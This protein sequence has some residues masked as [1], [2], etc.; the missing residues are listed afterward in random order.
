MRDRPSLPGTKDLNC[1]PLPQ[2]AATLSLVLTGDHSCMADH[3][4]LSS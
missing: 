2:V 3:P 1:I 4:K